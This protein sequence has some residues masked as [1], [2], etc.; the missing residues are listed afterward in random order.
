MKP[1]WQALDVMDRTRACE[2]PLIVGRKRGSG[3]L[4][5]QSPTPFFGRRGAWAA[6]PVREPRAAGT[7]PDTLRR[8]QTHAREVLRSGAAVSP[9]ALLCVELPRRDGR[10]VL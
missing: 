4:Q 2:E 7:G 9:D 5:S 3:T 8:Q 1:E 10:G 6:G